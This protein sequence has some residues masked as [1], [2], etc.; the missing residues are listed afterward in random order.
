MFVKFFTKHPLIFL[1]VLAVLARVILLVIFPV[2]DQLGGDFPLYQRIAD[3]ILTSGNF[4][5]EP[6]KTYGSPFISPGFAF[7]LVGWEIFFGGS[8]ASLLTASILLGAFLSVGVYMLAHH[9]FGKHIALLSGV[10]TALWPVFIIQTLAYGES[11]LL[12]TTVLVWGVYFFVR[13][14]QRRNLFLTALSGA[15][16]GFAAL[17]DAIAFFVPLFLILWA[18]FA[19]RSFRVVVPI[20]LFLVAMGLVL[21]PWAY[22]NATVTEQLGHGEKAPIVS[23]GE[24]QIVSPEG[25]SRIAERALRSDVVL[26]GFSRIFVFP[27]GISLL[28]QY[29]VSY[30]ERFFELM[31]GGGMGFSGKEWTI[32]FTKTAVTLLHWSALTLAAAASIT[33]SRRREWKFPMLAF[34]LTGY[35]TVA[36][37]GFGSLGKSGFQSVSELSSFLF[38]LVPLFIVL[39]SCA[40]YLLF[41]AEK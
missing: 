30:K 26:S 38:P 24:L 28:D 39:A 1:F 11:L 20:A 3:N 9:F 27:Y 34:L 41:N 37:I 4:G 31:R 14:V 19:R 7:F 22:R 13:A 6:Q 35:V 29:S 12:Y 25:L 2:P 23:K 10:I 16:L 40:P 33:L 32:L 5:G 18:F 15:L 21:A 8:E 36:V 17:V